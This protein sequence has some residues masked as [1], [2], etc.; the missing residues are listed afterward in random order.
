[1]KVPPPKPVAEAV[2][3][4]PV[5]TGSWIVP[6]DPVADTPVILTLADDPALTAG[7][8]AAPATA[9]LG[10]LT[11]ILPVPTPIA[12]VAKALV[13]VPLSTSIIEPAKPIAV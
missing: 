8:P 10:R 11:D 2:A 5:P 1:M 4:T 6:A 7:R 3:L 13:R 9:T 12:P